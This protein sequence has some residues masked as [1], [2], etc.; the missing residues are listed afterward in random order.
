MA[1]VVHE[2][3]KKLKIEGNSEELKDALGKTCMIDLA[4]IEQS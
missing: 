2:V 4:F 1:T 3:G